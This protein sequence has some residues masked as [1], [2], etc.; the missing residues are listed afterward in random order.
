VK[1]DKKGRWGREESRK[2]EIIEGGKGRGVE[3]VG[4][5]LDKRR[6]CR[7]FCEGGPILD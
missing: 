6:R 4:R 1:I 5:A 3:V 2:R 7:D